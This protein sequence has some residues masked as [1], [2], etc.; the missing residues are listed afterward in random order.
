V[1][2]S[3]L[4]QPVSKEATFGLG[5][6]EV[7]RHAITRPARRRRFASAVRGGGLLQ[8]RQE[9]RAVARRPERT[10]HV[11]GGHIHGGEQVRGAV[12]LV[13]MGALLGGTEIDGP[14]RLGAVQRLN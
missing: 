4:E 10:D 7:E 1:E 2:P 11:A 14:Q 13:V 8:A 3:A 9:L 12:P 5:G 6:R